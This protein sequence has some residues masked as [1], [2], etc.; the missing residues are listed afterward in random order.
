MHKDK[1]HGIKLNPM[2]EAAKRP[3]R[4]AARD[5][6][7]H[8]IEVKCVS[9]VYNQGKDNELKVL[10]NV[11]LC[12]HPGEITTIMGP[13]GSGKTTLLDII[14][15]L[16]RP[17]SG[18]VIIDGVDTQRLSDD[19]LARV[20]REKIGFVFQNFN[21]ITTLT[22][23]EN[24]ALPMRIAGM[25]K[26]QARER[27]ISLLKLVDLE[28]R[29][30]HKPTELSGGEQ[31]RVAI[32]RALAN[33]PKIILGD[34]LT[35]NLDSKNSAKVMELLKA[36][37]KTKGYTFVLVTHDPNLKNYADRTINMADGEII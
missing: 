26:A 18:T 19:E 37:N 20:R 27:A 7:R 36:L 10:K 15:C 17:T 1:Y 23:D 21:L 16:M 11:T 25:G 24:V 31:Q 12:L 3:V 35:G 5:D 32:A 8:D 29:L 6:H 28:N 33:N 13:S 30:G 14:G 4:S 22:A 9:K 34:E 2:K